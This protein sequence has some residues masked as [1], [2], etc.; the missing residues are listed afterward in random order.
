MSEHGMP[1]LQLMAFP[2]KDV[3][4]IDTWHSTGMR[5]TD[6]VDYAVEDVF[7]PAYRCFGVFTAEPRLPGAIFKLRIE[8]HFFTALASVGLG[9]AR[10]AIDSF[11]ELA[12]HKTPTLSQDGL[13]TRPTVHAAVARAE[14]RLQAAAAY[15]HEVASEID[16]T[17]AAGGMV[18]PPLEARRRLAGVTV[19][20]ASE[21][22]VDSMFRLAGTSV[23]YEGSVL[24]RCLRDIHTLNQ[25]IAVNPVWWE[26]TGQFYLGQDLGMP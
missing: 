3:A 12:K 19:A 26:K 23:I 25:H 13:A 24:D 16:A 15:L 4:I 18:S 22:V 17:L 5:S 21:D 14:A 2:R 8:A 10:T 11:V 20:E 7:V 9:V 6:S 1:D